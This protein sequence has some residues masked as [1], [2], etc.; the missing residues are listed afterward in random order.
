MNAE[1]FWVV[2]NSKKLSVLRTTTRWIL[3]ISLQFKTSG[4]GLVTNTENDRI[5]N[6]K[7]TSGPSNEVI[8]GWFLGDVS[9]LKK[10]IRF[11]VGFGLCRD[12][13]I[14]TRLRSHFLKEMVLCQ[15]F[16]VSYR[17]AWKKRIESTKR[18]AYSDGLSAL[19]LPCILWIVL[20]KMELLLIPIR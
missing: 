3:F 1:E 6:P 13:R 9:S 5:K 17:N 4:R 7:S 18:K 14:R 16:W 12:I 15:Y 10:P 8:S 19:F 11:T 2:A 20:T